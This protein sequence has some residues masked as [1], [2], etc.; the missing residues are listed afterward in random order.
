M[1]L[2]IHKG[3]LFAGNYETIGHGVN[4]VGVMGAG[5]ALEFRT[6]FPGMYQKY[7]MQCNA[8]LAQLGS[9]D[10]WEE[11]DF[12]TKQFTYGYNLFTQVM[13][14]S[15]ARLVGIDY[16]LRRTLAH[17]RL[18]GFQQLALPKIGCGIGG[19][20]WESQVL[21]VFEEAGKDYKDL[22]LVAVV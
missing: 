15:N 7:V 8:G 2:T 10:H 14:G 11:T 17:M 6:R 9:T 4:C 5:I 22:D 13:P 19:L 18:H 16:A 20:D 12:K 3:N 1:A 21:P